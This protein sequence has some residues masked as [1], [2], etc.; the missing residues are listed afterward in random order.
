VPN[1]DSSRQ[2]VFFE[3]AVFTGTGDPET[4]GP[5]PVKAVPRI[6]YYF[7]PGET[8]GNA[9]RN[10]R[11]YF[12]EVSDLPQTYILR[13]GSRV[14]VNLERY[15]YFNDDS[16]D[17]PLRGGDVIVIPYRQYYTITGEVAEAGDKPLT[18]LTRLSS[19]MTGLTAKASTRF[20]TVTSSTGTT[21]SCDLFRA[22]RF[23]DLSQ[24]PYIR[25]GDK[26]HV[27]AA[28]RRVTVGG[29]VFR[30]GEYELLPGEELSAVVGYYAGGFTLDA[31]PGRITLS[32]TG[33]DS[34]TPREALYLSWDKDTAF[35]LTDGD[36][37]TIANKDINRQAVFFEG[38]VFFITNNETLTRDREETNK[39]ISRIPYYFS[40]GETI[41]NAS[42]N[43]RQYFTEVSDLTKAYILRNGGQLPVN[44]E[45]Y[46][47]NNDDSEDIPLQ[48]GDVIVIPYRQ[49]YTITGEVAEAGDKPLTSL[50]RLSS[51]MTGLTAKA[52]T[53]FVTVT[54]AG[55]LSATY[56]LFQ[57]RRFGNLSQN[58]YIR[59]GDK[60]HIPAAGRR[61][62][63]GGEVFRPGEYELLP[64]ETLKELIEQYADGFAL[65]AN[66]DRIRLS[67]INT[68]ENI[69][70][71]SKIFPYKEN[72]GLALE[73]RDTVSVSNKIENRPVV[74]FE[75]AVSATIQGNVEETSAAIEGTTLLEYP[76]YKGETLGNATRTIRNRFIASSDLANAYLIRNGK[77]I[78]VDLNQFLYLQNFSNDITLENG[79]TIIVPFYQY[80]V[81]VTGAV[82]APGRYPYVPDRTANYYINLAGGRDDLLNNGRGARITDMNNRKLPLSAVIT[83]ET[84]IE[85]PI[86]RFT[87]RFNQY[88]PIITTI[89]SIL[90]STISILAV[91]GILTP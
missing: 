45:R 56:D 66:P 4:D 29:E 7:Y 91:T 39:A 28:G 17:V 69:P 16:A 85:V 57:S 36:R 48:S 80:F 27:P 26:I 82:K 67:R 24:D 73:D 60:I 11:Q 41:A 30:P 43:I 20:V 13:N 5:A 25:P 10:I 58:P 87:A 33:K 9:S 8:I 83:P 31:D 76:F 18:S 74:F 6:P 42:R 79:D 34:A 68:L 64:G 37:V 15:L 3:G 53:R 88:G 71:E 40:P 90:T 81:L 23:G 59:P 77:N 50:T 65:S 84:M 2:A 89:L 75:G 86:N 72:E 44:L 70:G 12:T 14:T 61:V 78:P 49:Y 21:T 22:R 55:G 54:S 52:S 19:L 35:V 47:F 51:L 46:L 1:K 38:A 32:R 62:T 63:V